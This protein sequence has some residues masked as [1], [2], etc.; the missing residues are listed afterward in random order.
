M[1]KDRNMY[2]DWHLMRTLPQ[3]CSKC[4]EWVQYLFLNH[5][6][7]LITK[8]TA[9]LLFYVT[10][11]IFLCGEEAPLIRRKTPQTRDSCLNL[12]QFTNILLIFSHVW[13]YLMPDPDF[14]VRIRPLQKMNLGI[15][16]ASVGDFVEKFYKVLWY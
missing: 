6:E 7:L 3:P 16:A 12:W 2:Q 13:H 8:I 15:S 14:N 9:V 4:A 11:H 1:Q 5:F 10:W